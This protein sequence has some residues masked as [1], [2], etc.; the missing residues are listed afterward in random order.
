MVHLWH[1]RREVNSIEKDG[2]VVTY[3][4]TDRNFALLATM[5]K[6]FEANGAQ[7]APLQDMSS[8]RKTL[9]LCRPNSTALETLRQALPL[10]GQYSVF[11]ENI[12]R[13][14]H[15][16][17]K[18]FSMGG[19]THVLFLNPYGNEHR[20]NLYRAVRRAGV[21]YWVHDR[22]ALPHSWF[23]DPSGFNAD[24][25]S[26]DPE[27]WDKPLSESEKEAV[28]SYVRVLKSNA[29]T[30][31][32]NGAPK[33]A[34]HWRHVL[35]AA[36]RKILFVPLQ[37]PTD[38]VTRYFGGEVG[39]YENFYFWVS[40]V[41]AGLDPAEWLVVVKKHPAETTR[42]SIPGAVFVPDD[43][44]VHD[45][46]DL[47]SAVL[48]V[49]S[50]VGVLA[51][52]FGKPVIACG[53]AFYTSKGLAIKASSADDVI[54]KLNSGLSYDEDT[55]QRFIHYLSSKFYSF[56]ETT[57]IERDLG[58]EKFMAAARIQYRSIRMLTDEPVILGKA[59][60]EANFDSP[61]FASFG[62]KDALNRVR[63]KLLAQP[64]SKVAKPAMPAPPI[65]RVSPLRRPLV[66]IVRPFV[67]GKGTKKDIEKFNADPAGFFAN[68]TNPRYR[69]IGKVLFPPK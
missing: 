27:K 33:S 7:P 14:E 39:P 45:L 61:L 44:H 17:L 6:A 22:G 16:L 60:P 11:D 69:A 51:L 1:P 24:S 64:E 67:I 65:R 9:V 2:N 13:D 10:V 40:R 58:T 43:A 56:G 34:E 63:Q 21:P 8:A 49:N 36:D 35:G 54:T 37:R 53:E 30:L 57:Y 12:F 29:E 68:L 31:E 41:A 15:A 62:G 55:V 46:I 47:S 5:M 4:Q 3:R 26:Y 25:S 18:K 52:A 42:P 48:L 23:F 38:T 50:G 66:S 19:F 20:L 28:I 59:P 32:K